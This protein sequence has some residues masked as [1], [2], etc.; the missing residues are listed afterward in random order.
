MLVTIIFRNSAA[1]MQRLNYFTVIIIRDQSE[2]AYL[3]DNLFNRNLAPE[4]NDHNPK[5][6]KF[7]LQRA[8]KVIE[9]RSL[10]EWNIHHIQPICTFVLQQ[11]DWNLQIY[12]CVDNS[13][14]AHNS[15]QW[16]IELDLAQNISKIN[17]L[18]AKIWNNFNTWP[19]IGS[20]EEPAL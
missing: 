9:L 18:L 4:G 5:F 1:K 12:I 7:Q 14:Q 2:V 16:G 15:N 6:I 20:L 19:L 3:S 17:Y 10:L 8:C 13:L 11:G